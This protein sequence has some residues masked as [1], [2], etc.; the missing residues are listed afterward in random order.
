MTV[1]VC[2][3]E[4]ERERETGRERNLIKIGRCIV[5]PGQIQCH[6]DDT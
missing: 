5:M 3:C 6:E 1:S 4:R 2:M